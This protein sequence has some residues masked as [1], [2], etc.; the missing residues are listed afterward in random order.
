MED[1]PTG[2][3]KP[4][5][6]PAATDATGQLKELEQQKHRRKQEERADGETVQHDSP[7]VA[8]QAIHPEV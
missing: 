8:H 2:C 6:Q 3:P 5:A 1:H 4:D 7:P